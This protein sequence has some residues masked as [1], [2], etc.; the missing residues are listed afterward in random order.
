[1]AIL[2]ALTN[3]TAS[4]Q[5]AVVVLAAAVLVAAVDFV[6]NWSCNDW[7]RN[8]RSDGQFHGFKPLLVIMRFLRVASSA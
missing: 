1:M 3:S 4:T 5:S 8:P 7:L 6:A 2:G